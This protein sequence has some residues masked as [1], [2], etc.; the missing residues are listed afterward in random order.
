MPLLVARVLAVILFLGGIVAVNKKPSSTTSTPTPMASQTLTSTPDKEA[1]IPTIDI[2]A[3][4]TPTPEPTVTPKPTAG[5][6]PTKIILP[7]TTPNTSVQI[8]QQSGFQ[9]NCSKPCTKIV[10]CDEAY[11]QL[12][13]C[14][15]TKRD[16]D[17]DGVPCEDVCPGG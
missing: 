14:G 9:C 16:G 13:Q 12:I 6:I 7:T 4:P 11:Y 10:S 1:T 2:T 17:K 15:C 8:Q 5:K 3:S